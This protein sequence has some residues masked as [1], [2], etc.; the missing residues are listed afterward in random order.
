[1]PQQTVGL[2]RP[3]HR[4]RLSIL[5]PHTMPQLTL[6][7]GIATLILLVLFHRT[8]SLDPDPLIFPWALSPDQLLR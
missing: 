8:L 5:H 3:N 1:M 7:P 6:H 4:R 2:S